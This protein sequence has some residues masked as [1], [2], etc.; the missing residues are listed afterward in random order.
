MLVD[1]DRTRWDPVLVSEGQT[2]VRSLL[3]HNRLG[4]YQIQAAV[5]AAHSDAR[6]ATDTDWHQILILYNQ[7]Y[8]L[9]PTPVVALN[10]AVAR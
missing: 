4:P 2:I 8:A 6:S 1:Q 7:L 3:R 5:N 9:T 10:R